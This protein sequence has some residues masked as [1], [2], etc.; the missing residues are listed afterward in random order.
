MLE[1]GGKTSVFQINKL[2]RGHRRKLSAKRFTPQNTG[3]AQD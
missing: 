2:R 1:K 3:K